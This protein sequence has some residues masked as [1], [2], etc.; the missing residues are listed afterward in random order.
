MIEDFT[1]PGYCRILDDLTDR[2]YEARGFDNIEPDNRHL[3][4]R[5]DLD[6][7]IEAAVPIAKIEAN[8]GMRSHY[9]V[10]VCAEL[11]NPMDPQRH[12]SLHH[13]M[14][15][16]HEVGLHLDASM[17]SDDVPSLEAAVNRECGVLERIIEA[18]VRTI[19]FHR[20][21]RSLL[22]TVGLIAGRAHAYEARFFHEIG[23]CSDSRGAWYHGHPLNHSAVAR[24][25]A[26]Q[27][28]THPIWWVGKPGASVDE[29]I[30]A[31]VQQEADRMR[32]DLA[33]NIETYNIP[34]TTE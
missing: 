27:L 10:R 17:Y 20:P 32:R 1:L 13:I 7:S 33:A 9:F 26:L 11:Y 28:L 23:Y 14:A 8:R 24:G 25:E 4:L 22:G 15:L 12:K 30:E 31:F 19:S 5:H 29:R 2:G 21:A 6:V 34:E 16:G 3:I 18:P